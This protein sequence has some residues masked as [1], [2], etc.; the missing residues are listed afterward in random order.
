MLKKRISP[1][2]KAEMRKLGKQIYNHKMT[3]AEAAV[4]YNV[5]FYTARNWLRF[6]KSE[7]KL[8]ERRLQ[9]L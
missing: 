8:K 9:D 6:Y 7:L 4:Y 5:N 1:K 2:S 3:V